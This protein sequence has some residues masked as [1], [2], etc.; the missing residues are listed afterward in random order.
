MSMPLLRLASYRKTPIFD[1]S[2]IPAG[3]LHRHSTKAGVWAR[4][5]V[6]EGTLLF[7]L[8]E[9]VPIEY[10]LTPE[11]PGEVEPE[12]PHEVAVCGPVRFYVEF[13][14]PLEAGA[15]EA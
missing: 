6:L 9:P 10:P 8:L 7:R 13:L 11:R 15:P 14:R 3:L 2:S 12:A 1:E 4:I 5:H